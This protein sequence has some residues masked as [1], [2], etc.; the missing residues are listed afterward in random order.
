M[1]FSAV[2]RVTD[3]AWTACAVEDS[4]GFGLMPGGTLEIETTLCREV[5]GAR[6]PIVIEHASEDQTYRTHHALRIHR[7]ESYISVP[8]VLSSG[9]YFGNL[10]AIDKRPF[11]I[12]APQF[13]EMFRLFAELI[14]RQLEDE[15]RHLATDRALADERN[16]A[17]LREQFIAVLGHDLRSPLGAVAAIG[18]VLQREPPREKLPDLGRRL[19]ASS[20]RMSSLIDDVLDFARGR[21]GSGIALNL[22][23]EHNLD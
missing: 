11:P 6:T 12:G 23:T 15:R 16:T 1:G 19:L 20:R 9:E 14:A 7:L 22:S 21:M 3:T 13:V 18:E 4:I 5:R 10:C 2:A 8:I 17:E